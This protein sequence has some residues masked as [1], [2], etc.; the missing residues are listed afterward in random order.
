M[1]KIQAGRVAEIATPLGEDVLLF[2]HMNAKE[3]MGRLFRFEIDMLSKDNSIRFEDLLGEKV[4]VRLDLGGGKN[5]YFSGHVGRFRHLL[6]LSCD[7]V[8]MSVVFDPDYQLPNLSA[9][10]R[11]GHHQGGVSR[12]WLQRL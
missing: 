9:E 4:T 8:P 1:G 2:Y 6:Q 12:A 7:R 3:E 11:P 5:R 10:E